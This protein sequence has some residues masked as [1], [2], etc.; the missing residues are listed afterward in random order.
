MEMGAGAQTGGTARPESI[1][2]TN[3]LADADINP[4]EVG[5][6]G[7]PAARVAELHRVAEDR[8]AAAN[9]DDDAGG[10]SAHR[11]AGGGSDI[12]SGMPAGVFGDRLA[13]ER[14]GYGA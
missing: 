2:G 12:D 3:S 4:L 10:R 9:V 6:E 13:A 14:C 1:A 11:S 8:I 7:A 5:V